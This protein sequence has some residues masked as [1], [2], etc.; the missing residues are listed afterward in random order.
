MDLDKTVKKRIMDLKKFI[1][2]SQVATGPITGGV[3]GTEFGL[4][5]FNWPSTQKG[6]VVKMLSLT[7]CNLTVFVG[8]RFHKVLAKY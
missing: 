8:L 1:N 4:S 7:F 3:R 5:R 2:L 6:K